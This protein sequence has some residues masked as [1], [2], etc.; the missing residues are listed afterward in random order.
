MQQ[1]SSRPVQLAAPIPASLHDPPAQ[2]FR[3]CGRHLLDASAPLNGNL[4]YFTPREGSLF[5]TET[6]PSKVP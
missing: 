4:F 5:P 3:P 1:V 6:I 2:P